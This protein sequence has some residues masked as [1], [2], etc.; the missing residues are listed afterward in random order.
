MTF[1]I[2]QNWLDKNSGGSDNGTGY[3][4]GARYGFSTG[5]A[6]KASYAHMI[7][8]PSLRQFYEEDGGNDSLE[9]ERSDNFEVAVEQQFAYNTMASLTGFYNEVQDYIEK[10]TDDVFQNHDK[11]RFQGIE[12]AVQSRPIDGLW[13]AFSYTYMDSQ[14][15]SSGSEKDELQYRPRNKLAFQGQY[16]WDF[17]FSVYAGVL[18]YA[19][20][21]YYSRT[22]PLQQE[23]LGNYAVVD[24]KLAQS[25]YKNMFSVYLGADNVFDQDYEESYGYPAPGRIIYAGLEARF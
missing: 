3:M 15:L 25:F 1:G 4:A 10:D 11:Y 21:V 7:R 17:G 9:P 23:S 6:L 16:L 14:D 13:L 22:E 12:F 2:S 18:Y 5:T 19:D 8:F 20:Q 24:L